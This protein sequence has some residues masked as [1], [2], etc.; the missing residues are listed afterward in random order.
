MITFKEITYKNFLSTGDTG[1]T[2]FLDR[3]PSALIAG[4][5]GSGKSTVLDALCFA[6]FNKPYRNINK[7]QL[8]NSVNEKGCLVEV[9]FDVNGT[10]YKVCRGI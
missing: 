10:E 7:P 9:I 6:I 5:N 8:I 3:T 1:N 4:Q 2:I